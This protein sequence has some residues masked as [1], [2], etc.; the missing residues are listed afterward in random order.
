MNRASGASPECEKAQRALLLGSDQLEVERARRHVAT[1]DECGMAAVD[2]ASSLPPRLRSALP[3]PPR[4]LQVAL[5]VLGVIQLV[6]AVPWLVGADPWGLLGDTVP[7]THATR[8]GAVEMGVS[9]AAV[10]AAFRPRWARPAFFLSAGLVVTQ[11]VSGVI[12]D[13]I[14]E[15]G[16]AEVIHLLGVVLVVMIGAVVAAQLLAPM[17]VQR[18]P[19]LRGVDNED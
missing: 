5:L 3:P 16:G 17:G 10:M 7:A 18:R 6:I 19:P 15:T 2:E 13:S 14:V 12:D 8:D 11:V 9:I 4:A 1:C